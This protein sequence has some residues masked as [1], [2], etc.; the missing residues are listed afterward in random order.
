MEKKVYFYN[1]KKQRLAGFLHIPKKTPAP[2]IILANGFTSDMTNKKNIAKT[3]AKN[4]FIVLRF[5]QSGCGESEGKFYDF[6]VSG[7]VS[8][9]EAAFDFLA[10]QKFVDKNRIGMSGH[11]L[12]GMVTILAAAKNRKIKVI[13]PVDSPYDMKTRGRDSE[14]NKKKF[15]N[16]WK[17][18]GYKVFKIKRNGIQVPE[19]LSY[20]FLKD[21]LKYDASKCI[22][23]VKCPVMIV[24]GDVDTV[25]PL[26]HARLLFRNANEPKKLVVI[27]GVN[28]SFANSKHE[29]ILV[30]NMLY[31]F[32]KYLKN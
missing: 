30:E 12:G 25:V 23:H 19:K 13:V 8:D 7:N 3:L 29:K 27:K 31:W 6:T 32:N 17:R 15:L 4:G 5:D 24:H 2:T 1:K 22:K 11:S 16:E 20:N 9:C 14:F 10:K 26:N 28:H 18:T 21:S